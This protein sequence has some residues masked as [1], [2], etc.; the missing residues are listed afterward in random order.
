MM[1]L[2]KAGWAMTFTG[3]LVKDGGRVCA[4]CPEVD[5]ATQGRDV[6][7]AKTMLKEA[8]GDYIE[9]CIESNLP[10][11]RPVSK[12]DD[13]RFCDADNVVSIFRLK[14]DMLVRVHV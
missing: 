11:L 9:S 7:E 10:F 12:E 8:V 14:V 4:L 2:E 3:V 6:R 13:P 1:K 5:V